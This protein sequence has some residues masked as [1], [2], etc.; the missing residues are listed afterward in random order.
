M[1]TLEAAWVAVPISQDPVLPREELLDWFAL[2]TYPQASYILKGRPDGVL[3]A[4]CF[5]DVSIERG[6]NKGQLCPTCIFLLSFK[7]SAAKE[8]TFIFLR[9]CLCLVFILH[10]LLYWGCVRRTVMMMDT[11]RAGI[12]FSCWFLLLF[13]PSLCRYQSL[14]DFPLCE[15]GD[16][17][18]WPCSWR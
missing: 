18:P 13:I 9:L 11:N 1:D 14:F 7:A 3:A 5:W 17:S 12:G 16:H 4:P 6:S 8:S 15:S 10:F 2:C